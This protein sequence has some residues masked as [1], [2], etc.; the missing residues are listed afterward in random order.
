MK[1]VTH[2]SHATSGFLRSPLITALICFN[3]LVLFLATHSVYQ[4]K[5]QHDLRAATLTLNVAMA[6]DQSVS[7]SIDKIEFALRAVAD[8]LEQQLVSGSLDQTGVNAFLERQMKRLPEVEGF[9]V[10]DAT[11]N[12]ILGKDVKASTRASWADRPYFVHLRDHDDGALQITKPM[13]GRV[14]RQPIIGF[15]VRY[16]HPDGSF[17]GV[18]SAPVAVSQFTRFLSRYDLGRNGTIILRDRDLGLIARWP[19]IPHRAVGQ[20]GNSAVSPELRSLYESGAQTSTY[21]TPAGADGFKRT[22]TLH[23]IERARMYV[24]SAVASDDYLAP[25]VSEIWNTAGMAGCFMLLSFALGASL[26]RQLA[27]G[28][29]HARLIAERSTQLQTLIEVV[30]DSIQFKDADGRWLLA[31]SVCLDRFG[32]KGDDWR[33]RTDVEIGLLHPS[34]AAALEA[35]KAGDDRAWAGAKLHRS[36]EKGDGH[37]A[38]TCHEVIRVPLFDETGHRHAMVVVARDISDRKRNEIELEQHRRRLEELVEQRTTALMET[39]ARASH[40]VQSS[41]AGLFGVDVKGMIT[42]MNPAACEMLGYSADEVIGQSGHALIHHSRADGSPYEIDDCPSQDALKSGGK[43]RVDNEV[44]WHRDGHPIPVTYAIHPMVQNGVTTGAVIS[45]VDMS[46]QQAAARASERAVLAAEQLARARSEF[47]ANRSHEIRTPFSGVLGFADIGYRNYQ[48]AEKAREAF[49]RIQTSGR[50]LLGVIED[51]L[52]FSKI[53]AGK[54]NIE[55]T[56]VNLDEVVDHAIDLVRDRARAKALDLRVVREPGFPSGC[57]SDPLRMGQVLLNLLSNAVKFTE[58]GAVTLTASRRGDRLVF[59]VTDTGIGM[60]RAQ[61]DT[62]FNPFEQADASI[63][64]RF[65]GSGLGMAISKRI[66]DLMRGYISASSQPGVGTTV[67]FGLPFVPSARSGETLEPG[68][69]GGGEAAHRVLEGVS[70]L[71]VEDDPEIRDVLISVLNENGACVAL[72]GSGREA[73]QQVVEGGAGA[74]HIVLMDIQMPEMDGYEATRRILEIAPD[75]PVV[76][77]TAHAFSE[78][79]ERCLAAGMRGHITKPI[80]PDELVKRVLEYVR[81]ESGT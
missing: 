34:V 59:T 21:Y 57:Q 13:V 72:A 23:R 32:L 81:A 35:S 41:A 25:W 17:A 33:G 37:G 31:N 75:L 65:G 40:I 44:Y 70:V 52:D 14:A 62:L 49:A 47:L 71:V 39:E 22:A 80:R 54:L 2:G 48:N 3:V 5:R 29:R 77:Q 69:A 74:F 12:V 45:F 8:E 43:L 36:E 67:E 24:V 60:D 7:S 20:V 61:L 9:R 58:R 10:S 30:P 38:I 19:E 46:A 55:Q 28:E 51:I 50:R 6:L 68:L 42:F 56:E 63:T 76:A 73:V 16:N 1:G 11:G 4:S 15:S 18:V 79:R 53:E 78:E 64:R 27:E 66:V 26:L